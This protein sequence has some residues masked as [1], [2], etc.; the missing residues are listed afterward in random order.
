MEQ[1]N[2]KTL[3]HIARENMG[4]LL[5]EANERGIRQEDI[6]DIVVKGNTF[7]LIYVD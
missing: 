2:T 1:E 4:A 6:V 7:Y 3:N 5:T